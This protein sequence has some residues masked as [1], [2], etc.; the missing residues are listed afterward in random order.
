[1]QNKIISSL[2]LLSVVSCQSISDVENGKGNGMDS[3]D[4]WISEVVE[5]MPAPGQFINGGMGNTTAAAKLVG[6]VSTVSLGG[7]GGYIVFRF[8]DDVTNGVGDDFVVLGN[9]YVD[10]IYPECSNSEPG[11]VQV[12]YD[13]NGNGKAD[14]KWYEL[15]GA[16]HDAEGVV[17]NYEITYKRP[18]DLSEMTN[19]AWSDNQGKTGVVDISAVLAFHKNSIYP[20]EEFFKDG[21]VP[22]TLTFTG[23]LLVPNGV[24]S[25][26]VDGGAE[27]WKLYALSKGYVDNYSPEYEVVVGSDNDTKGSNKFDIA[28]AVDE[29][30]ESVNLPKITFIKVYSAV[31]Q[32]CGW[33]GETSTE[34][35]GAISLRVPKK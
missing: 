28:N 24:K 15:R 2:L 23:T 20:K 26:G 21:K 29:N 33:I 35:C 9:S 16:N 12:S 13:E 6:G 7:F 32:S 5:Y 3:A 17:K 34:V 22:E 18:A 11:I 27:Y 8:K 19:V 4:K 31:S 14:D 30:G 25:E 1:M 10:A